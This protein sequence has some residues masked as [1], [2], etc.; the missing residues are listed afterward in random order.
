M[1]TESQIAL[2]EHKIAVRMEFLRKVIE[3]VLMITQTRGKR[4]L[5]ETG[6]CSTHTRDELNN[7]DGF[8]FVADLGKYHLGDGNEIIVTWNVPGRAPM[9]VL[10]ASW[11]VRVEECWVEEWSPN[12]D[13]E[14]VLAD[15]M[16]KHKEI[17]TAIDANANETQFRSDMA[18]RLE[19]T[20]QAL[21]TRAKGL[22]IPT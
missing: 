12:T 14:P 20:Y 2:L 13:W 18:Q 4:T 21:C 15:T 22:A 17:A 19:S 9:L 8:S 11:Q 5:E 10:K 16:A 6:S 1:A 3:F 7:F